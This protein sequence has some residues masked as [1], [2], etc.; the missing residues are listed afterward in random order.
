[1]ARAIYLKT[2]KRHRTHDILLGDGTI[3]EVDESEYL[4]R[5]L[6]G[7]IVSYGG[8]EFIVKSIFFSK[9][10]VGLKVKRWTARDQ[11]LADRAKEQ[12][13]EPEKKKPEKKS[14]VDRE[15]F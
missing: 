2:V 5:F 13:P 8:E 7:D 15:M 12:K 9:G 4:R 6:I 1:M 14:P 11:Q 10:R 3:F